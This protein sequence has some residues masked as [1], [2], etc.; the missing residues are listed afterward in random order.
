MVY[1]F[2]EIEFLKSDFI[3]WASR[4][5]S[6]LRYK[7]TVFKCCIH[8][9]VAIV[10][11]LIPCCGSRWLFTLKKIKN[12]VYLLTCTPKV[13]SYVSCRPHTSYPL[14]NGPWATEHWTSTLIH[15]RFCF[16]W[17]CCLKKN[18]WEI[19][20]QYVKFLLHFSFNLVKIYSF[21]TC[22]VRVVLCRLLWDKVILHCNG[23]V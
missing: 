19:R 12:Y 21:S 17:D 9:K 20:F 8:L 5:N 22:I 6:S 14:S 15:W 1:F 3:H 18:D 16:L 13:I 7:N 4:Q 23:L 10:P 2:N 11:S